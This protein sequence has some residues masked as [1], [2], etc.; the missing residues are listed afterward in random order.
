FLALRGQVTRASGK[1]T[2]EII[3]STGD[4][5]ELQSFIKKEDW[6]ECHLIIRNN[7]MIHLINGHVMSIVIDD[8]KKGRSRKGLIGVQVHV[9]PPMKIEYRNIRLKEL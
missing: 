2:T 9:G 4:K 7:I 1:K 5:D 6:N 3:G 8:D